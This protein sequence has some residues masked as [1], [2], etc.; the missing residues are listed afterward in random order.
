M[1]D[2]QDDQ[3]GRDDGGWEPGSGAVLDSSGHVEGRF[4]ALN[5]P[6]APRPEQATAPV[7]LPPPNLEPTP[8]PELELARDIRRE[9]P[10]PSEWESIPDRSEPMRPRRSVG[11]PL[12]A[13]GIIA[14]LAVGGWFYGGDLWRSVQRYL[15]VGR[16]AEAAFLKV[17]SQ[18]SGARVMVGETELGFTPLVM[19]NIWPVGRSIEV[20]VILEGHQTWRGT[21]EGGRAQSLEARL[22]RRK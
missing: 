4:T 6:A 16:S 10:P 20:E 18:P 17:D 2:R 22:K 12:F 13:V 1:S 15:P 9:A 19:D 14:A 8:E 21:F 7:Q 5:G 11:T 3:D